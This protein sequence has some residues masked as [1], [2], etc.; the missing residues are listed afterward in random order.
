MSLTK[1]KFWYSNSNCLHNS[2]YALPLVDKLSSQ[3]NA[4][5]SND[6]VTT[7]TT[8]WQFGEMSIL[9]KC[10]SAK[11]LFDQNTPHRS[12]GQ[13]HSQIWQKIFCF[14]YYFEKKFG[15]NLIKISF[16]PCS[17]QF[18]TDFVLHSKEGKGGQNKSNN[19]SQLVFLV[20]IKK[21]SLHRSFLA[22]PYGALYRKILC[23]YLN[24]EV[25]L[26]LRWP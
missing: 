22:M 5:W 21:T 10:L 4:C 20:D 3:P 25:I 7:V 24:F 11:V 2:K 8:E 1:S 17:N 26:N 23:F 12:N 16:H 15:N 18:L 19:K 6:R 14:K 13:T 9:A